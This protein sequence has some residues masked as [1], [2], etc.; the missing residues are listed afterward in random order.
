[1][2]LALLLEGLDLELAAQA[3]RWHPTPTPS[4]VTVSSRGA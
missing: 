2:G 1:M 4:S 3:P